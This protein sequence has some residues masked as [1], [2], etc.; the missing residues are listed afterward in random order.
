[1]PGVRLGALGALGAGTC[2]VAD[3]ALDAALSPPALL[4]VTTKWYVVPLFNPLTVCEVAV[5]FATGVMPAAVRS[6][7]PAKLDSE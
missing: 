5:I 3:P 1:M 2:G 4:A 7:T 6:V